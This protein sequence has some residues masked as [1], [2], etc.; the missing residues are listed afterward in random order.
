MES[1]KLCI[2]TELNVNESEC[3]IKSQ[4]IPVVTGIFQ[5]LYVFIYL[6]LDGGMQII[7]SPPTF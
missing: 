7:F 5:L 3:S 4:M 2:L 6:F 1:K